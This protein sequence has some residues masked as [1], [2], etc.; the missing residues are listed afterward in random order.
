MAKGKNI[1]RLIFTL[2]ITLMLSLALFSCKD[3]PFDYLSENLDEYIYI[4]DANYTG[5]KGY[6]VTISSDEITDATVRAFINRILV[7]KRGDASNLGKSEY[8][9][10]LEIGDDISVFFRGFIKDKDGNLKEQLSFSNFTVTD[11]KYRIYALGAGTLDKLGLYVEEALVGCDLSKYASCQI[12]T[13]PQV[14][15]ANDVVYVSYDAI[16]NGATAKSVKEQ[17]LDL[18]NPDKEN[19]HLTEYIVGKIS[20]DTYS[21][22]KVFSTE[23]GDKI[24]YSNIKVERVMRFPD[25]G[26][27]P[28][29][30][31]TKVPASWSETSLQGKE[32]TLEF[33]I[34][35]TIKYDTPTFDDAFITDTLEVDAA[36][37]DSYE[38]EG[39]TGKY[40]TYV[41]EYLKAV[42]KAEIESVMIDALW[43]HLYDIAEIKKL[44]EDEVERIYNDY[45]IQFKDAF[46]K[47]PGEYKTV[48]EFANAYVSEVAGSSLV[49]TDYFRQEAEAEVKQKLIFYYIVKRE[50][51][52]PSE[53]EFLKLKETLIEVELASTLY[54]KG[55]SRDNFDSDAAYEAA[56]APYR[57]EAEAVY[58]DGEYL[59]WSVHYEYAIPKMSAFGK[60]VYRNPAQ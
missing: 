42:D 16:Y 44:P 7:E 41:K 2:L 55:I 36:S 43:S 35:Y 53:E 40:F 25:A 14:I 46:D 37:L 6:E 1:I 15:L 56:V 49:W 17:R 32:I 47:N 20:G 60:V 4:S 38:G 9:S 8:N 31:T 12:L 51:L 39:L 58:A 28:F 21:P 50:N 23:S 48:D 33:F 54:E 5:Y 34:D 26:Q 24:I 3:E 57:K 27:E 18:A 19:A 13:T 45:K 52:L 11:E 59:N 30:V 29:R 10:T 22:N